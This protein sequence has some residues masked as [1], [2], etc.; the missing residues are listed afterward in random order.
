M[1][2]SIRHFE[3]RFSTLIE[4]NIILYLYMIFSFVLKL[5]VVFELDSHWCILPAIHTFWLQHPV[6]LFIQRSK[7]DRFRSEFFDTFSSNFRWIMKKYHLVCL[8]EPPVG[9]P[10]TLT[11]S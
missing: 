3:L 8:R 1:K 9:A 11:R 2:K 7:H 5:E 4:Y 6:V 10:I